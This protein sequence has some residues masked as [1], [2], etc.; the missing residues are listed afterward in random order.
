MLFYGVRQSKII[1]IEKC[2]DYLV[3]ILKTL[4][5]MHIYALDCISITVYKKI[6]DV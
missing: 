6:K 3:S 4:S 2:K 5:L 1:R